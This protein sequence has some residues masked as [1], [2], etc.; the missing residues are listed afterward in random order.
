MT[1][2]SSPSMALY[3]VDLPVADGESVCQLW[4]ERSEAVIDQP[5]PKVPERS[6][7]SATLEDGTMVGRFV[8]D[9]AS[10]GQLTQAIGTAKHWDAARPAH[11]RNARR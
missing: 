3:I 1:H 9:P 5:E 4:R 2:P 11:T 10:A 8:L 6:W 7:K